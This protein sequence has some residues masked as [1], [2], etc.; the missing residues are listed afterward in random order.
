MNGYDEF[1]GDTEEQARIRARWSE[2]FDRR[3][4]GLDLRAE[5]E[6]TGP[7]SELDEDGNVVTRPGRDGATRGPH[8]DG[9]TPS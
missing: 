6:A 2:G 1:A 5:L 3:S 4:K 9:G 8:G 7:Y